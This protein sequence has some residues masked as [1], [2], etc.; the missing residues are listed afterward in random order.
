MGNEERRKVKNKDVKLLE[1]IF[2][3][4]QDI[5]SLEQ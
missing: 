3:I 2:Y 1:R 4:M 5:R